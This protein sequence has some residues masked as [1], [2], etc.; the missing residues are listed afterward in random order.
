MQQHVACLPCLAVVAQMILACEEEDKCVCNS[1]LRVFRVLRCLLRCD[2]QP[3]TRLGCLAV[4]AGIFVAACVRRR[5]H[6]C[7]EEDTWVLGFMS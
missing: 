6:V 4:L 2:K 5:I 3:Q 7:E 1:T